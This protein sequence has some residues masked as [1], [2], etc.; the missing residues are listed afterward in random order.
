MTKKSIVI[1]G[2][3][4]DNIEIQKKIV[5]DLALNYKV[6][7][8]WTADSDCNPHCHQTGRQNVKS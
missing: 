7:L 4:K 6:Y 2:S 1:I 3:S 5:E 8:L